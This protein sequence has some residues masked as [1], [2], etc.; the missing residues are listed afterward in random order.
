M[1]QYKKIFNATVDALPSV[2]AMI[3]KDTQLTSVMHNKY[4]HDNNSDCYL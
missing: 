3:P 2:G 4:K 1:E